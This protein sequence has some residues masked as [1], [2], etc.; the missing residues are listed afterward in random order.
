MGSVNHRPV[1]TGFWGAA[2]GE[3]SL[4][5]GPKRVTS[6]GSEEFSDLKASHVT[7]TGHTL[8]GWS[9]IDR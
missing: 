4:M 6:R 7:V 3:Q 1:E 5:L 9:P 8:C 2:F